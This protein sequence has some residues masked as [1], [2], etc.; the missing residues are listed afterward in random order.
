MLLLMMWI[1]LGSCLLLCCLRSFSCL[2]QP[3]A[4]LGCLFSRRLLELDAEYLVSL[5][6]NHQVFLNLRVPLFYVL[7]HSSQLPQVGTCVTTSFT[8]RNLHPEKSAMVPTVFIG[9]HSFRAC[10]YDCE[11]DI[12]FTA[13]CNPNHKDNVYNNVT[14]L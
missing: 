5:L 4:Q 8:E 7:I 6:H 14:G 11:K 9:Q 3:T 1:A 12:E 13:S 10:L 2:R